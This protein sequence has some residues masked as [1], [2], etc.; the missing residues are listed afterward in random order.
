MLES[1]KEDSTT[2]ILFHKLF[3]IYMYDSAI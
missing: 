1:V 3:K 2:T